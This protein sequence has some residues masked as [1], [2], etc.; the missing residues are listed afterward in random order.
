MKHNL[1]N[2]ENLMW[3]HY[4][5]EDEYPYPVSYWG[6]VLDIDDSGHLSALYRWDPH[7]YCHFHRHLCMTTSVVLAGELHVSTFENGESA[8]STVRQ[9][10]H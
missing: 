9:I 5:E 8:D 10:G 6:T 3:V 4:Q 1:L 7:S 2:H